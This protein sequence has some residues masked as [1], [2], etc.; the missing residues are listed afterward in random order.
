MQLIAQKLGKTA[1]RLL[2]LRAPALALCVALAGTTMSVQAFTGNARSGAQLEYG[3]VLF[4]YFQRDYFSALI[5][6]KY[7]ETLRNT[8]ALNPSGQ[9]LKGGM[10][11]SYGLA[12]ES[13]KVFYEL[14]EKNA[15]QDV[16]NRAW[17]YLAKLHYNKSDMDGA[18]AAISRVSGKIPAD[19]LI[20]YHYLATLIKSDNRSAA[21]RIAEVEK[22]ARNSPYFPYFLFNMAVAYLAE[23]DL[24]AAV[25]TLERVT[26][27]SRT[28]E[29]LSVLSDRARHG[30]SELAMQTEQLPAAWQYLS[31]IRTTGL[32]SNR[33]L[34]SYVWAAINQQ[35]FQEAIPALEILSSRSV[36]LPEV[37]EAK[38]LLAHV[39]EQNGDLRRALRRNI[40][41]EQEF[42][43]GVHLIAQAREVIKG[44]DVPREFISNLEAIMDN[45]DW[46]AARPSVDYQRLTPFLVDLMA[47]NAFTEALREL[48]DLYVIEDNLKYWA[49]QADQ[50]RLILISADK[51]DFNQE[52][53]QVLSASEQLKADFLERSKELSLYSLMLEE[54]ERKRLSALMETTS[55]EIKA[56]ENKVNRL[57][58]VTEPYR[59]P[60]HFHTMVADKHKRIEQ[61]LARTEQQIIALEK[62]MRKLIG[63][64]LDKHEERMNYYMAQSRLAKARLYDM[65][66]LSLEGAAP[67]GADGKSTAGDQQR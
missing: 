67:V 65:T 10:M 37:Q 46:Y 22:T 15:P 62:I 36:A 2:I 18:K 39:Y 7:A 50:H 13:E 58:Q 17:Y 27:Y 20:D 3:A 26:R 32:Y 31:A 16:Q 30:L 21:G 43:A 29:E 61:T 51:K 44:Q 38:V 45:T 11:L 35:Q 24:V 25:E 49:E 52:M 60:P 42:I 23:G 34:L 41:A 56:M 47:S 55:S 66:L 40:S 33:A 6:Q 14:L 59:Q 1:G 19:I 8:N 5:E 4:D 57:G 64:E 28:N 9:L 12:D 54:D 48:A 53:A 63:L